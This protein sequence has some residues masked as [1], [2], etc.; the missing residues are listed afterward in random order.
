M[1]S[2]TMKEKLCRTSSASSTGGGL[3][4]LNDIA[5]TIEAGS[6]PEHWLESNTA[7]E[8]EINNLRKELEDVKE[9]LSEIT[10]VKPVFL[11]CV[12]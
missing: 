1:D 4:N 3:G 12:T 9:R 2:V 8:K 11:G 7:D 5:E 10:E 6:V